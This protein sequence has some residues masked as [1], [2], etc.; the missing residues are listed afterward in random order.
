MAENKRLTNEQLTQI[1]ERAERATEGVWFAAYGGVYS[2]NTNTRG[3]YESTTEVCTLNDGEY[4]ENQNE[5]NDAA[6]I[7][8]AREDIPKL[9]AEVERMRE[10]L[11]KAY[12]HGVTAEAYQ[13][14]KDIKEIYEY[15]YGGDDE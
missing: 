11:F 5:E 1:R 7:A 6:F 2:T 14:G 15:L 3:I 4:I 12:Q 13:N 9:L 8:H 10:L